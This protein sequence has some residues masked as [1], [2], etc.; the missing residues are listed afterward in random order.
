MSDE[1]FRQLDPHGRGSVGLDTLLRMLSSIEGC[2][3]LDAED[4]HVI[5][6]LLDLAPEDTEI[7]DEVSAWRRCGAH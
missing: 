4:M 2:E 6:L 1:A 5:R 3:K 7:T